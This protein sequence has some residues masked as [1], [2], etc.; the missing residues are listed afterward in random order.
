[1]SCVICNN[2]LA[3]G[4]TQEHKGGV[5]HVEC[6]LVASATHCS[7]CNGLLSENGI[8]TSMVNMGTRTVTIWCK[9]C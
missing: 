3:E 7:K 9:Q 1:M 4:E 6:A 5:A 2:D 8:S